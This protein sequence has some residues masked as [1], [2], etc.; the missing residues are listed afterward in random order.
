MPLVRVNGVVIDFTRRAEGDAAICA[1]HKHHVSCASTR[2]HDAGEHVNIVI[3]GGAGT[4]DGQEYHS[5]QTCWIDSPATDEPT[6]VDSGASV[7]S[8]RLATNLG[9]A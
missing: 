1:A 2:R 5:I 3:R 9:V 7:K 8:W 4:V 6:H